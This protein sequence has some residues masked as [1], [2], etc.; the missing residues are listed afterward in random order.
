MLGDDDMFSSDLTDAELAGRLGSVQ[1]PSPPTYPFPVSFTHPPSRL[2]PRGGPAS[3]LLRACGCGWACTCAC[4]VSCARAPRGAA[5][6]PTLVVVSLEDE[7]VP[8]HV[9][10]PPSRS[11]LAA[12]ALA[13]ARPRAPVHMCARTPAAHLRVPPSPSK[14]PMDTGS[15]SP[16][17]H[18]PTCTCPNPPPSGRTRRRSAAAWRRRC[19]GAAQSSCPPTTPSPGGASERAA[20]LAAVL[21][22]W[23][24]PSP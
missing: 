5:Q 12:R 14:F 22:C 9:V 3:N 17:P 1:V 23:A 7:Y 21:R 2:W 19:R 6:A 10:R 20:R 8:P 18:R 4:P 16:V 13:C 11:P 24:A 15:C